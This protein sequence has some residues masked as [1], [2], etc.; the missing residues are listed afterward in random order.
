MARIG[1]TADLRLVDEVSWM[2]HQVAQSR[3]KDYVYQPEF[4]VLYK[5]AWLDK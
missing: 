3:M 5:K 4:K 2:I 1:V